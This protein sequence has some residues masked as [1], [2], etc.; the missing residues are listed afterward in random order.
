M[1]KS[2]FKFGIIRPF[3]KDEQQMINRYANE[4]E[5]TLSMLNYPH[6]KLNSYETH[7]VAS[8]AMRGLSLNGWTCEQTYK[9]WQDYRKH[10]ST[11]YP[12]SC[13][14]NVLCG[15]KI[16]ARVWNQLKEW[17]PYHQDRMAERRWYY[18]NITDWEGKKRKWYFDSPNDESAVQY[19]YHHALNDYDLNGYH[20]LY[21]VEWNGQEF[22]NARKVAKSTIYNRME[23][24]RNNRRVQYEAMA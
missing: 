18:M 6:I 15:P 13:S 21:A 16:F 12:G 1:A 8:V 2:N 10:Y 23:R 9:W 4:N 24:E 5:N 7:T 22:K 19:F 14:A 17:L 11:L 20:S 3:M